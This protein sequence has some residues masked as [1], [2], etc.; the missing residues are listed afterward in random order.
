MTK[1][2][3][4]SDWTIRDLTNAIDSEERVLRKEGDRN[5]SVDR[6]ELEAMKSE[7]VARIFGR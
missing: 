1:S 3:K 5:F 2:S 6:V 7:R 4:Y